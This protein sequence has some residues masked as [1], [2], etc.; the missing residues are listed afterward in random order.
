MNITQFLA[1]KKQQAEKTAIRMANIEL[2][3]WN[4]EHE[5]KCAAMGLSAKQIKQRKT[6]LINQSNGIF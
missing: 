6:Y 1:E 2:S 4:D 3:I 5:R